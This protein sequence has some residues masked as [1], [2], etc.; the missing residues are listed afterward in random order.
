MRE[1]RRPP[2][3]NRALTRRQFAAASLAAA[4]GA[5]SA[6]GQA[7]PDADGVPWLAEVQQPPAL[8]PPDAPQ[9]F[10]LLVDPGRNPIKTRAHWEKQRDY[11]RSQWRDLIGAL[12]MSGLRRPPTF[13]IRESDQTDGVVRRRIRYE[14][15]RG[16][17]TEAYLL[18]PLKV[19]KRLP[20]VVVMHSTVNHTI[21]QPAGLEGRPEAAW[22]LRLAQRGMVVICP[23][24][25]LWDKE[26]V[27]YE[28]QAEEH[29]RRHSLS[30]PIAKMLYD[31][32]RAVDVLTSLNE[33]DPQRI[34]AAGHSL[35]AKEAL[36]LAAFDTRIKAAVSSE[37]G[38]GTKFS[39][40]DAPWYWG[41]DEFFGREHHELLAII[42]PR[43]FLL[44]GGNAADG[45]R[46]WPFIEAVLP[47]YRFFGEPRRIGLYN[48]G[49]GHTIPKLAEQRVYEWLEAYL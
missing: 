48:H 15:E 26:P 29:R 30:R 23:R 45:D 38:I 14:P 9:L 3:P 41:G 2:T 8:I 25:F 16:L 21:R 6:L 1:P 37:G 12:E 20:G 22:G 28:R 4:C 34:G 33:V 43:A 24:C 31:A 39:N 10:P 27:N 44:I 13:E 47:I 7:L 32:Q 17:P 40:W 36:Y 42:A 46:S 35:G 11:L 49:Q 5:S 18:M 19:D